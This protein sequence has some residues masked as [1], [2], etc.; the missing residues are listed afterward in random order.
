MS[1]EHLSEYVDAVI[2]KED[3]TSWEAYTQYIEKKGKSILKELMD[4]VKKP[5]RLKGNDVLV[6]GKK[7][8]TINN[9]LEGEKE[10]DEAK[11]EYTCADTGKVSSHDKLANL[12]KALAKEHKLEESDL[13]HASGADGQVAKTTKAIKD[14]D[15]EKG[16]KLNKETG[17][18]DNADHDDSK[19]QHAA[20]EKRKNQ[21]RKQTEKAIKSWRPID[22]KE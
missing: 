1:K 4:E 17:H 7:V 13:A 3:D 15:P 18:E 12:F 6:K 10:G 14:A 5:I 19:K 8:G 21:S 2:R 22:W 16:L 9:K 11:I 20:D